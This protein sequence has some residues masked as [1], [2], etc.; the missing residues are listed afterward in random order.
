MILGAV[1][2]EARA[3]ELGHDVVAFRYT[4]HRLSNHLTDDFGNQVPLGED[5]L[6][7]GFAALLGDDEHP[8]LRLTEQN[9][10]RRHS[11]FA[12]RD[13]GGIDRDAHLTTLCHLGAGAG[14][15]CGTHILDR[16]DVTAANEFE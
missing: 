12:Y 1:G 13:L 8:L 10:I 15:A 5:L 3:G 11:G 16:D 2:D 9:L 4:V 7:L 14:E 6:D